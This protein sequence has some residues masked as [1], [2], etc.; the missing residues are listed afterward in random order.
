MVN[1]ILIRSSLNFYTVF[2]SIKL[3]FN[4][5]KTIYIL[6]FKVDYFAISQYNDLQFK[7]INIPGSSKVATT[8]QTP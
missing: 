3:S 5:K 8:I 4:N 6:A 7:G 2:V 1:K